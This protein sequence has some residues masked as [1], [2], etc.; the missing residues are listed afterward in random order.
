MPQAHG[1]SNAH[2]AFACTFQTQRWPS[3][4][5]PYFRMMGISPSC[6]CFR[7]H[8]IFPQR[9]AIP[10]CTAARLRS[11][12]FPAH[13]QSP[14]LRPPRSLLV[15]EIAQNIVQNYA[16]PHYDLEA[17]LKSAPYCY[18]YLC[19]LFRQELHTTPHKY[20]ASLRLQSAADILRTGSSISTEIPACAAITIP[21][22]SPA[23]S[24]TNSAYL[25]G[26]TQNNPQRNHDAVSK[27]WRLFCPA[28]GIVH[29]P[30]QHIADAYAQG[31]RTV[32]AK[33]NT[34]GSTFRSGAVSLPS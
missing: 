17:L 8:C 31:I 15:E 4:S 30:A 34:M 27:A 14:R 24:K 32:A 16:N 29:N 1:S 19:R 33:P 21:C 10:V 18:D 7:I 28:A 5:R 6:I 2:P 9:S 26:N 13:Q 22:T 23:C 12:D 11:A 3:A 20:L 25:P